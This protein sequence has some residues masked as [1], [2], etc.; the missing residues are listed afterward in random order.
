MVSSVAVDIEIKV[1]FVF[2]FVFV[3]ESAMH[4]KQCSCFFM[5]EEIVRAGGQEAKLGETASS[6]T[7]QKPLK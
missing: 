6:H 4:G 1:L 7:G 3:F 2:V 5:Q